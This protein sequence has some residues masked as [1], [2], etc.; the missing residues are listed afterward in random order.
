M[1]R[2]NQKLTLSASRDIPFNQLILSQSNVRRLKAGVSIEEL[3]ADI[4]RRTLLASL[5][6]RPVVDDSGAETGMFEVPA[7]GRRFRALELLVKQKRLSR[8]A[9]VPC[10][11]RTEGLAEEDSLAEN[12]QRAPLHPLDQFRA[13]QALR[14]KG[15]GEEEIA[16]AFFVSA[17]V[18]RQRL[19]LA[20]VAP[21]LLE[22][23]AEEAMT[24]DQLMAFTV[25]P[26]HA[27]QEQVWEALQRSYTK[28]PYEI[29][30]MLTESAVRAS[31]RRAQYVGLA[32]Y[33]ES[34]GVILRDLF[35]SDDGGW[36]Q[37]AGLL[38]LMVTEKLREDAEAI[39]GE[40]WRW[41][42]VG[43]DFP[44][45]H[46]FGLRRLVGEA[47]PMSEVEAA[48]Y[49]AL[50]AE[51]SQLET[52]HA[53]ADELPDNV[54]IRL[55]EIETAM[56]VLQDRP[57]RF[58]PDDVAR[59]GAFVSIDSGGRL[60]IERGFVRPEDEPAAATAD[61]SE[62]D[63]GDAMVDRTGDARP[64][65]EE[66]PEPEEEDD[67]LRP[68]SDRLVTELT[69]H[70]TL[71][72]RD[73][74]AGDPQ[75]ACL[76]VLHALALRLFY[77][78][79]LASCLE[80]E[81]RSA[82]FGTQAPGLGQTPSARSIDARTERWTKALPKAPEDL[83]DALVEFDLDSREAL[84]AHCVALTVNAV[85]EAYN[86]RP[87]AL[88]HADLLATRLGLDMAAAGWTPTAGAYLG[89]VTKARI[90]EAVR[91]AK[92]AD[93]ADRIAGL[94]KPEMVAAAE[95]LLGGTGWLPEVLRTPPP[96][97]EADCTEGEAQSTD[98]GGEPAVGDHPPSGEDAAVAPN[99]FAA[100]Q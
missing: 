66:T 21:A 23:C 28:A 91:E 14:E 6:V 53:A 52:E 83:W 81:P 69:A 63:G 85:D 97:D 55:G 3:A 44:Y 96:V 62:G 43:I 40:G 94:R 92:G 16:A 76:A 7:G 48:E 17:G 67:G 74:L 47:E 1:T 71:A 60:R 18:V 73:A 77:R 42:E 38:E 34:G 72:L 75:T 58:E 49:A 54:D 29:R 90:R 80:I 24:L 20:A 30:R 68:L 11:V 79:G 70:R 41:V 59:A 46:S 8:T 50:D 99:A 57:D 84:F 27:R 4:A 93:A 25:N 5:T 82:G 26:D 13:F 86:H 35:Q 78:Y 2:S 36:L 100:A 87:R 39:C 95:E 56:G 31:D 12:V 64:D 98:N 61:V 45:G 88:A 15:R 33:E 65:G 89:R 51:R 19:K 37:D 9:P 32:A 10:I 22:A